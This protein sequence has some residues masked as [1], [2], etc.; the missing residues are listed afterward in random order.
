MSHLNL[1]AVVQL[2]LV[3]TLWVSSAFAD[4]LSDGMKA[5][6]EKQYKQAIPHFEAAAKEGIA[7]AFYMLGRIYHYL[8][9]GSSRRVF[10]AETYYL[11][12]AE[13]G[14]AGAMAELG[15]IYR[16]KNHVM[17]YVWWTLAAQRGN[18]KA[19]GNLYLVRTSVENDSERFA[20]ARGMIKEL[21]EEFI[22]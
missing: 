21:N 4:D 2:F 10:R 9:K 6:E 17:A 22:K 15:Y 7:E 11:N 19:K 5:Y 8:I 12:A 1:R 14:H 18:K 3:C 13:L 16:N 20:T